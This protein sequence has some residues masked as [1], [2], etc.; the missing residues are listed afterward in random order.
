MSTLSPERWQAISP[1]L[2]Q[3]LAMPEKERPAWLTKLREQNPELAGQVEA[4]LKEHQALAGEG[5]LEH[6]P[7]DIPVQLGLAGQ[8]VGAYSLVSPIGEGGMGSVWLAERSDGRFERRAAVKFLSL[9][10]AGRGGRERFQREGAIL[11]RL[12][13]SHIAQLID[14]GVSP[15]GQPYLVLEHVEGQ[16]IDEY[17]DER[18]LAVEA[19][20]RL[21]LDVLSAVA[22]AHANLVVHRD[23]KPSNVL[24]RNDGQVKLLDFGI[25]KLLEEA[26]DAAAVTQL[27]QQAGGA[28][29]PA[30]AAPEQV[31]GQPVTTATDVYAL[32]VLLYVLL[33]GQHP[34]GSATR[35]TADLIKAIVDTEPRRASEAVGAQKPD[36][37]NVV[38]IAAQ[39]GTTPEKLVRQL[40]GDLDTI[41]AKA[42]KKNPA[43]RY[44]SVTAL[45]DDLQRYLKHEP[46]RARPDTVRYRTAKFVRRH[47]AGLALT[48]VALIA[49]IAAIAGTLIQART[50]RR[51]RDIALRERDRANR[52]SDFMTN[53]FK[54]SD[55]NERI[56]NSVTAR[57]IL[58]KASAD[59]ETGLSKDP[60]ARARMMY[61]MGMA[62]L[63]LGLYSRAEQLLDRSVDAA[64]SAGG[65]PSREALKSMQKLAWA[66]Y[67][68]GRFAEAEVRQRKLLD[69]EQRVLGPEDHDTVGVKGDLATTLSEEGH[70]A[71]AEKLQREVLEQQ[72]RALGPEANFTVVSMNNLAA[73]L[74][75]EQRYAEAYKLQHEALE[76]KLRVAGPENLSTI[77]YWM[78]EATIEADMGEFDE[79]EKSL[80]QLLKLERRVLRPNQP[81]IAMTVYD[82]ATV[83]AKRGRTDE[84]LSLLQQAIDI[85]LRP[86]EA[87][88]MEKDP[89][90]KALQGSPGFAALV[91]KAKERAALAQQR[92]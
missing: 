9:A 57:E 10:L 81:E 47:R 50:A 85:G 70:L 66:L 25:A 55:P 45:A 60:E 2:D 30:Y 12:A 7:A 23:L 53:V 67:N 24:V 46:I 58:D 26:S 1:Y 73:I 28:L 90:L 15:A 39:R 3:A 76:I 78:N 5:F 37:N 65:Q 56:G 29:T 88:Q 31:T 33:T 34:A 36:G 18:R 69:I 8:T 17:C 79:A 41:I 27:T 86:V 59:I 20:L 19:R 74:V 92:H 91:A 77:H 13:D 48:A 21:F 6:A 38:A 14:A 43:E 54:V 51:Q 62:Y 40:R 64:T 44:S 49:V 61:V 22:H 4:L 71:E 32:G 82:L 75:H 84:A 35:S 63:N 89:A 68:Q 80:R 11:G 83:S 72:T 42:L 87:L 16:H 52:I